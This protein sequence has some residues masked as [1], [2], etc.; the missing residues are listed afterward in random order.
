M[1]FTKP[2]AQ[3][4]AKD[5]RHSALQGQESLAQ[6]IANIHQTSPL[7]R[8]VRCNLNAIAAAKRFEAVVDEA[9]ALHPK[10]SIFEEQ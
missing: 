5:G 8:L 3:R 2:L 1:S 7:T 10:I 4:L 6:R 9:M